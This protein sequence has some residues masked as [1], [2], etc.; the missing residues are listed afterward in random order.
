MKM[1]PVLFLMALGIAACATPPYPALTMENDAEQVANVVVTD[2]S[3]RD[4]VRVGRALVERTPGGELRVVVPVR[5]IDS[6]TIQI[7]AQIGYLDANAA[8]LGDDSNRQ[9]QILP[10]GTTQTLQWTSH[11]TRAADYVVRLSWNK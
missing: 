10:S 9:V 8:P 5:N 7:L 1:H 11:D 6:E 4:V 2:G 3:L